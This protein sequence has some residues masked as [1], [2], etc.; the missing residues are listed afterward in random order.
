MRSRVAHGMRQIARRR[1]EV[2]GT[3]VAVALASGLLWAYALSA[4]AVDPPDEIDPDASC[5]T[6]ECH[7]EVTDYAELHWEEFSNPGECQ[8][9]HVSEEDEHEF[10]LADL[11]DLCTDCHE[12]VG[13]KI[14]IERNDIPYPPTINDMAEAD[15]AEAVM[16]DAFG[17]SNVIR[18]HEPTMAG[19]DFSFFAREVPGCYV[20]IGNGDSKPLHNAGY[21]FN[22]EAAPLGVAYWARL[23]ET[24]LP[25]QAT[26]G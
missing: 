16:R 10:E 17:D 3:R 6:S 24:A 25:R 11:P 2:F 13:T 15:F 8:E 26:L 18:G 4:L 14:A 23:V 22:D 9:C 12:V 7:G 5:V 21:D 19:E 20:L 1:T